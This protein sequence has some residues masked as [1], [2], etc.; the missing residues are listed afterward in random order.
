MFNRFQNESI[1]RSNPLTAHG[2]K[3]ALPSGVEYR[4]VTVR[5][6][7]NGSDI[8]TNINLTLDAGKRVAIVDRTGGGKSTRLRRA[9]SA[10]PQ[11]ASLFQGTVGFNLDPLNEFSDTYLSHVLKLCTSSSTSLRIDD[12]DNDK[13]TLTSPVPSGG[14]NF[15]LGQRQ[16]LSL[17]GT[18]ARKSRLM[19]LDETTA[20]VGLATD[21]AIQDIL[22]TELSGSAAEGKS[23]ITIAHRL[24]TI[25]DYDLV[26]VMGSG[27][28]LEAGSPRE[29]FGQ[30]GEFY[31]M[32]VLGQEQ[33]TA[34]LPRSDRQL[35][36]R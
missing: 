33:D 22:R 3:G 10:I 35:R 17:C 23:L 1:A 19:L 6:D 20:S 34:S 11:V 12:S 8:L 31:K 14:A 32:V 36:S 7:I 21:K 26:I 27:E 9:I 18:L 13:I 30:K 24:R 16:I 5:H 25:V 4:N 2:N 15:S 28:V 29:L